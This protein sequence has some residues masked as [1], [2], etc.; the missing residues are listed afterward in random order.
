MAQL[1]QNR[2]HKSYQS[3]SFTWVYSHMQSK[4]SK[5]F[6]PQK[7][8]FKLTML[9]NDNREM[10]YISRE[11]S[12]FCQRPFFDILFAALVIAWPHSGL[13]ISLPLDKERPP[14]STAGFISGGSLHAKTHRP[15]LLLPPYVACLLG[16][17]LIHVACLLRYPWSQFL[18][19]TIW[20]LW[21]DCNIHHFLLPSFATFSDPTENTLPPLPTH[22]ISS[23]IK[24]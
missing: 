18:C 19:S 6:L 23:G 2:S 4:I 12:L 24:V 16:Y 14:C 20:G 21:C 9:L 3:N 7:C 1:L 22:T 10:P 8:I 13:Y 15:D 17:P 5:T 11:N